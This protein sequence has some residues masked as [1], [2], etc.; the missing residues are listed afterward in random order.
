MR[1]LL[2]AAFTASVF[3]IVFGSAN[4]ETVG[5]AVS[6]RTLVT[7]DRGVFKRADPVE[8]NERIRTDSAGLGHFQFMDGSKLAVGPNSNITVDE[9]V[10]GSGNRVK[11]LALNAS[12]GALR[13]ISGKSSSSAYSIVTPF[14]ALGV[15]GTAVDIYLR[16]GAATM[17][18][19][20]GEAR[21]C[22]PGRERCVTVNRP[23]DF[24]IAQGNTVSDPERVN[25]SAVGGFSSLY[26]FNNRDRLHPAFRTARANCGVGNTIRTKRGGDRPQD[27]PRA[28]PSRDRGNG[29]GGD[30]GDSGGQLD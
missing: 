10:L 27:R 24:I 3:G 6:V 9:Y 30:G 16:N 8:R 22:L 14:G 4:A 15:R 25:A 19:L 29:D 18:L 17:I 26:F 7:G 5:K 28:A 12:R 2:L 23:C 13:W 11:S 1:L 20:E 21:W